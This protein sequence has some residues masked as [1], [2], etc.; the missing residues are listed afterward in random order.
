M[1]EKLIDDY[2]NVDGN[3]ELSDEWTGFTRFVLLNERPPDGYIW[4]GRRLTRKHTTPGPT[5]CGQKC[6]SICLMHRNA[7]QSKNGPSRNQNSIMPEDYVV[8]SLLN[9][10]MENS[11][12]KSKMPMESWKFRCQPLTQFDNTRRNVFVLL[13]PTN[14]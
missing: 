12:V 7:K 14:L 2:W 8:F 3:R 11:S 5:M 10:M 13:R 9:L 4:S 1:S 6:G